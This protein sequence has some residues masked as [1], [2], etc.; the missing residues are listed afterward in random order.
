M[1]T[2]FYREIFFTT[3]NFLKGTQSFQ[4]PSG[5][6]A[7]KMYHGNRTVGS[8]IQ[9]VIIRVI[10]EITRRESDLFNHEYDYRQNWTKR[11]SVTNLL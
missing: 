1:I 4:N 11:S 9:S 10:N 7:S 6:L 2:G 5:S 8:L 3:N